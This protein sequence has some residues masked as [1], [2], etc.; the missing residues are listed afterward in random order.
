[1]N[2]VNLIKAVRYVLANDTIFMGYLGKTTAADALTRIGIKHGF[3]MNKSG[4]YSLPAVVML[5]NEEDVKEYVKANDLLV[6]F[7]LVNNFDE[8]NAMMVLI[9][10]KDRLIDLLCNKCNSDSKHE[11]INSQAATLGF[12]LKV[13]DV[14]RVSVLTY[15]DQ[16]Q[17]SQRLHKIDCIIEMIVGD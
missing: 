9:Q 11:V 8:S 17:G 16:E 3:Y 4:L 6:K 12:A 2:T 13:R 10:M 7:T 15:D 14:H 5:I 1:M